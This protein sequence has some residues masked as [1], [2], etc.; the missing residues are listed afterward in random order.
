[1]TCSFKTQ[2]VFFDETNGGS[3]FKAGFVAPTQTGE[4]IGRNAPRRHMQT[5]AKRGARLG[6]VLGANNNGMV[7]IK[8]GIIKRLLDSVFVISGLNNVEVSVIIC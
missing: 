2:N 1:M 8:R 4:G 7:I 3:N 6:D 5:L